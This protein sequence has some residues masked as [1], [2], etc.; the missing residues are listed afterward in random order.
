MVLVGKLGL[1]VGLADH[2]WDAA[3]LG[4]RVPE[5]DPSGGPS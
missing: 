2:Y 5:R 4:V 1:A 3:S